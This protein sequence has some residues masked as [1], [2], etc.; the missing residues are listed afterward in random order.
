MCWFIQPYKWR[1]IL[2]WLLIHT[3]A[4]FEIILWVLKKKRLNDNFTSF[5]FDS[6]SII[7]W[8]PSCALSSIRVCRFLSITILF[9]RKLKVFF[10]YA[11]WRLSK[12]L[13]KFLSCEK[14]KENLWHV[15]VPLHK[16]LLFSYT[17]LKGVAV[18]C[19]Q[20]LLA[21]PISLILFFHFIAFHETWFPLIPTCVVSLFQ[22]NIAVCGWSCF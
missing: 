16:I 6:Y 3:Y 19:C 10:I 4:D 22:C 20:N 17:R 21:S 7:S 14:K 15:F 8:L 5:F 2:I 11:N 1:P 12:I 18:V 13:I 9:W